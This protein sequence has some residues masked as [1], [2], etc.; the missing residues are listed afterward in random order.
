MFYVWAA[1]ALAPS[2]KPTWSWLQRR[3]AAGWLLLRGE[4]S[5]SAS[6]TFI[7][8][9]AADGNISRN[10]LWKVVLK[11]SP[12]WMPYMVCRF[13]GYAMLDFPLSMTKT[14][15]G[16]CEPNPTTAVWSGFSGHWM[17][18]YSPHTVPGAVNLSYELDKKLEVVTGGNRWTHF[19]ANSADFRTCGQKKTSSDQFVLPAVIEAHSPDSSH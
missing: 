8:G 3:R 9:P 16:G 12:G 1:F 11:D 13:F 10:D 4:F 6:Q 14:Q 15:I 5:R 2:G 17:A 18:F 7:S 19:R